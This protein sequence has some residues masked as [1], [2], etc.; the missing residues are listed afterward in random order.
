MLPTLAVATRVQVG[1]D[2]VKSK[3]TSVA[4]DCMGRRVAAV[5]FFLHDARYPAHQSNGCGE[6]L[7]RAGLIAH[8]RSWI[9]VLNRLGER[10][11]ALR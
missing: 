5:E 6:C 9:N 8:R 11:R 7:A 4:L 3:T 2:V 1:Y 10:I